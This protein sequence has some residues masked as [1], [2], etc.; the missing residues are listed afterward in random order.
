MFDDEKQFDGY[1]HEVLK[2]RSWLYRHR[3]GIVTIL[4][5]PVF[6][7]VIR[8][9]LFYMLELDKLY[10]PNFSLVDN[11]YGNMRCFFEIRHNNLTT[12]QIFWVTCGMII[13][14]YGECYNPKTPILIFLN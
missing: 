10:N 8:N 14:R 4:L 2:R 1:L 12:T 11:L 6:I 5:I 3:K 9:K 7:L 13:N